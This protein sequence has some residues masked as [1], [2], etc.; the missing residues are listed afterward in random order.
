[1]KRRQAIA[2]VLSCLSLWV[3]GLPLG[4]AGAPQEAAVASFEGHVKAIRI[5]ICGLQRG[6]C[7]GAMVLAQKEG[8]EVSLAIKPGIQIRRG[9]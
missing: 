3:C 7:E 8:G 4:M 2:M 1:M 5:D 9:E 6:R